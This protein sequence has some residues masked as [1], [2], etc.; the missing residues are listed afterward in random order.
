MFALIIT[1]V[2]ARG[3][4]GSVAVGLAIGGLDC[5]VKLGTYYIHERLWL[6]VKW[7]HVDSDVV[8]KGG[9]I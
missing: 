1:A 8:S 2:V 3:V 6:R 7:G 5:L 4:T 9:G